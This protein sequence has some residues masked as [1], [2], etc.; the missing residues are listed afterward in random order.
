MA[1]SLEFTKVSGEVG[2]GYDDAEK[3]GFLMAYPGVRIPIDVK[4]GLSARART[5]YPPL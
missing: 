5:R 2:Y 1:G 3:G 4:L